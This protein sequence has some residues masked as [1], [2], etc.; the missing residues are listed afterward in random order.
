MSTVLKIEGDMDAAAME[1][2]RPQIE[3]VAADGEDVVVDMA[4]VRF[5]D[6]SGIGGIV[7]MYKRLKSEGLLLSLR[8]LTGQPDRILRHMRVH[9]L[10][11]QG[12]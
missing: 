11:S 5:I 6:S 8:N 2:L 4:L 3:A 10:L 9:D 7:Y 12:A 1:H